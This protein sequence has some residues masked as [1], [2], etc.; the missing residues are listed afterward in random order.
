MARSR[1]RDAREAAKRK[2]RSLDRSGSSPRSRGKPRLRRSAGPTVTSISTWRSGAPT[3]RARVPVALNGN[4]PV[5]LTP[6][7][8]NNLGSAP[9]AVDCFRRRAVVVYATADSRLLQPTAAIPLRTERREFIANM[10]DRDRKWCLASPGFSFRPRRNEPLDGT[11]PVSR[12][13][14]SAKIVRER[15]R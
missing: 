4:R 7:K 9:A 11:T 14:I 13:A 12:P 3:R 5:A 6:T 1:R 15:C 8:V 2:V 10:V